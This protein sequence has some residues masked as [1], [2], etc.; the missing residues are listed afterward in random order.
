MKLIKKAK[1]PLFGNWIKSIHSNME[2]LVE[3]P[4]GQRTYMKYSE[5][6]TRSLKQRAKN[7]VKKIIQNEK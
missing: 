1:R 4:N 2:C 6:E 3:L 5:F 7:A